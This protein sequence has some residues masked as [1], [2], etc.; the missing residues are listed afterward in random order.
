MSASLFSARAAHVHA[1]VVSLYVGGDARKMQI[2]ALLIIYWKPYCWPPVLNCFNSA[3]LFL[4]AQLMKIRR[5]SDNANDYV[6]NRDCLL[7][8]KKEKTVFQIL[9][10][11]VNNTEAG[12]K[13]RRQRWTRRCATKYLERR[14]LKFLVLD[15]QMTPFLLLKRM[16]EDTCRT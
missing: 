4:F 14:H 15:K 16:H 7:G 10:F 2:K 6:F 5:K 1:A 11:S 3:E 12:K 13:W 9:T 8:F